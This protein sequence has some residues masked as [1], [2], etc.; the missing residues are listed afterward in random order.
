MPLLI[1]IAVALL[2]GLGAGA[3]AWHFTG[4]R[5]ALA[6]AEEVGEAAGEAVEDSPGLRRRLLHARLDP[7]RATG[8]ALTLALVVIVAGGVVLGVLAYLVR[9]KTGL[10]HLDRSVAV[11]GDGHSTAFTSSVIGAISDA[12]QPLS[13][14]GMAIVLGVVLTVRTRNWAP[15]L[16]LLCVVGGNAIITTTIKHLA[17]RVRPDLNTVAATLGPSFPSGHSS[18]S[19]AF[20]AAAA[21][22]LGRHLHRRGQAA[23]AG[24][25]VGLAVAVAVSRVMLAEH[26]L[27]DVVA[28]LALGWA[29]F[30]VCAI[31]FGGRLLTFGAGARA[32]ETEARRTAQ[33]V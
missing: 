13:I 11:W 26:W 4:R 1:L 7:E 19:A 8:L 2:A 32:A 15:A 17:N 28:G 10:V 29:W 27:S 18:H 20:F 3:L 6:A 25:A 23:L 16:F 30:S 22:L 5:R 21:L 24:L 12:G 14:A 33:P 9:S 31:A